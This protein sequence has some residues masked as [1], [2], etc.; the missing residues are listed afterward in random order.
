MWQISETRWLNPLAITYIRDNVELDRITVWV[1]GGTGSMQGEYE[2]YDGTDRQAV[3][4]HL[5]RNSTPIYHQ[6]DDDWPFDEDPSR[7]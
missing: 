3:I 4:A 6:R 5:A 7:R 1:M 2:F